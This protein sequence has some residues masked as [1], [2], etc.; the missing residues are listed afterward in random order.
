MKQFITIGLLVALSTSAQVIYFDHDE[1]NFFAT[2]SWAS[3]DASIKAPL[4]ET[5]IDCF[6]NT[7]T[8]IEA[9]AEYYMGHPHVSV[10]YLDVIKWDKDGV[11]A[12]DASGSCMISDALSE[13]TR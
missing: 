10:N 9:T 12:T 3:H 2:G 1:T 6:K 13:T 7:K 8:C 4:T 11:I 5:E